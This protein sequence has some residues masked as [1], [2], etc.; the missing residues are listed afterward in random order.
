M[1][2]TSTIKSSIFNI[3]QLCN[4]QFSRLSKYIFENYGIKMPVEK[5]IIL[6][7]RL[8]NRLK[9]LQFDHFKDYVDYVFSADGQLNEARHMIDLVSTNKTDFYREDDHFELLSNVILDELTAA[10]GFQEP[11]NIWSA[12]CS[13]GEEAYTIAFTIEEYQ[14]KS[15]VF[16]Y[17]IFGS[18]ISGRIIKQATEAIYPEEKTVVIPGEIK[19]KYMLKSK[20]RK[21]PTLRVKPY[22]RNKTVFNR[23][24]LIEDRY[25]LPDNL[26]IIFCRNVLIY[27][28]RSTQEAVLKKLVNKLKTGGFLFLGHSESISGMDLPLSRVRP[29]VF[30]KN[31]NI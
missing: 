28:N 5:K 1:E 30:R 10:A 15:R 8:Q 16:D 22:I 26:D 12:G 9:E 27:F 29:T 25:N 13:S 6:Q 3:K 18:D 21:K 24:N 31:N 19:R 14:E 23:Q 17:Q 7:C 2:T 20:D 4:D 11:M